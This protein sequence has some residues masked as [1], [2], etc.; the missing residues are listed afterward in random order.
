MDLLNSKLE[1]FRL[2][3]RYTKRRSRRSTFQS[4]AVY[5]D[6][7]YIY[8]SRIPDSSNFAPASPTFSSSSKFSKGSSAVSVA[9]S[10]VEDAREAEVVGADRS[11]VAKKRRSGLWGGSARRRDAEKR[12]EMVT[13]QEVRW[14]EST[15]S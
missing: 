8:S 4:D 10:P 15:T 3:Q 14:E 7:E 11:E 1:L 5:V 2:E 13:V 12:R 6:G 9:L